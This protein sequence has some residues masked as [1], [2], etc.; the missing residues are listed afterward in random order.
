MLTDAYSDRGWSD[1]RRWMV[2]TVSAQLPHLRNFNRREC[3]E[4][5]SS[6]RPYYTPLLKFVY[7]KA[8]WPLWCLTNK[9]VSTSFSETC[10]SRGSTNQ[11]SRLLVLSQ[12]IGIVTLD[13]KWPKS[14]RTKTCFVSSWAFEH[15]VLL[16]SCQNLRFET[17]M[18]FPISI[19]TFRSYIRR[20]W[21]T[22]LI[23]CWVITA[24][25]II[26][27]LISPFFF[28][29]KFLTEFL[30]I[31]PHASTSQLPARSPTNLK[32]FYAHDWQG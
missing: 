18:A 14:I 21:T 3:G 17:P 30:I 32:L 7:G 25:K 13:L 31:S 16:Y 2:T 12:V 29:K 26:F 27:S 6:K 15:F 4:L 9:G 1:E 19:W 22:E 20:R 24:I 5:S 8:M 10:F 11:T 23:D 28:D